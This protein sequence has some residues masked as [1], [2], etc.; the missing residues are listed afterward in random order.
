MAGDYLEAVRAVQPRGPY[1]LGGWSVGGLIASEMA[2][3]LQA[4]GEEV[5]L[6]ALFDTKA[7]NA[8]GESEVFDDASLPASFALHL[9]LSPE[10]LQ[11]AAEA[12]SQAHGEDYL[13]FMLE[14]A[15]AA[16]VIPHDMS[17][18]RLRQ[19]FRVF[20]ANVRAARGY[21]PANLPAG[22]ALFRAAERPPGADADATLG[23]SRL[24]PEKI[25]VHEAPGSHLTMMREPY[26]SV[27][28]E[29]LARCIGAGRKE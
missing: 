13:P 10:Q 17:L 27:L 25:E 19:Q 15:K 21:R 29:R 18:A 14:H 4:R 3:Q 9:G 23:W 20:D 24:G 2:R 28:A 6:L 16:G 7:P 11:D 26:V 22:I 1:L 5:R 8:E 12:L